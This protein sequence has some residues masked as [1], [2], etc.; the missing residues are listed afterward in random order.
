MSPATGT[1]RQADSVPG[2]AIELPKPGEPL[3][4]LA[5]HAHPDDE[6]SKGAASTLKYVAEG[7]RVMVVTCTGGERGDILNKARDLPH[8]RE[9]LTAERRREMAAAAEILGIEHE[10]LGF[11]DSGY[12][13]GDPPPPIP[14]GSFAAV[15]LAEPVEKLVEII[16]RF[17]PHVISTYDE[18]GGYP[19]PDHIRTHEIGVAAFADA[20]DPA[21]YPEAGA[22]WQPI[23]LYYNV[24]FTRERFRVIHAALEEAGME[25]PYTDLVNSSQRWRVDGDKRTTTRVECAQYFSRRDD[26]LRAHATQ[27]EPDSR[28]FFTPLDMQQRVW[29]TEDFELVTSYVPTELPEDDLFAGVRPEP[30][31]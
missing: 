10:W 19:H 15:P 20:G 5:V 25:S 23:K 30:E 12:P 8:I 18:M 31:R 24:A 3:R 4:W 2:V 16:R 1:A 14:E 6:S 9:D 27:V 11:V 17:K 21:A 26:A 22:P 28:W 7:A 13:E 29:P